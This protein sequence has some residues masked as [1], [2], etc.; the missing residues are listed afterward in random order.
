MS[1]PK[2]GDPAPEFTLA[3]YPEGDYALSDYRGR[4]VVLV[5]YPGD[6]TPVCTTQLTS[7][8][9]QLSVFEELD[10]QVLAISPQDVD[11]HRRWSDERAF[12]FPLL[13]D[14]DRAV[15]EQYGIVGPLGSYRRSIFVVD[16]TGTLTYVHRSLV[17]TSFQP[18]STILEA[19]ASR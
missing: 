6:A 18:V 10:A 1:G 2:V 16:G 19:L 17:A 3:G 13:A 8:N 5:F 7:Y 15:G 4:H 9:E 14:T 11:S 12:R